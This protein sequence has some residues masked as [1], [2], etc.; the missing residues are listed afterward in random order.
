MKKKFGRWGKA[1]AAAALCLTL[2][3]GTTA[4]APAAPAYAWDVASAIGALVGVGAQYAFAEQ[5]L[6]YLNGQGRYQYMD[7]VKQK[8]GVSQ[9]PQANAMLKDIMTR[10]SDSIAVT[11]P[12]IKEKPYNYFVN[13]QDSFNAFCTV[14]HNLSVNIGLFNKLNYNE[15]EIAFVVA[16]ELGHGE[17]NHPA[18]G[19]RRA[20]PLQILS[21]LYASQNPNSASEMGAYLASRIGTAKMVTKPME[22]EAD[23]LAFGY[24]V[25]AGYNPGAGS[26]VWQRVLEKV[27]TGSNSSFLGDLFNDHPGNISRRDKYNEKIYDYSN[28][29]VKVDPETGTIQ[30]KDQDFYT[31]KAYDGMSGKERAYLISGNLAAV[32]H[33]KMSE[34][35]VWTNSDNILM[36]GPQPIMTMTPVANAGSVAAALAKLTAAP[37]RKGAWKQERSAGSDSEKLTAPEKLTDKEKLTAQ[38]KAAAVEARK[39]AALQR[40]LDKIAGQ[41]ATAAH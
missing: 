20:L 40:R 39:Q 38:D 15:D 36:V 1:A 37:V 10:L 18:A 4:W 34:R 22:V 11:D 35:N 28:K 17:K 9:D 5:Q 21:A 8:V 3:S 29:N 2:V 31:P 24:A 19:V 14:G 6:S 23:K 32:F 26:A 27:D 13:S 16:H 30:I 12:S 33:N 41:D 25:G 7:Q